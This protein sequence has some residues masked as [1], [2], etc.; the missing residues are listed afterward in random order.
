[1]KITDTHYIY[2]IWKRGLKAALSVSFAA[3]IASCTID[4]YESGDGKYSYYSADMTVFSTAKD[5]IDRGTLDDDRTL[6][7]AQPISS[8]PLKK[9]YKQFI[10]NDSIRMMLFYNKSAENETVTEAS[11]AISFTPVYVPNVALS[12]TLKT[13][14]KNDPVNL[15]SA[16]KSKNGKYYNINI[17]VK[18]GSADEKKPHIIGLVCDSVSYDSLSV[19]NGSV[20]KKPKLHLRLTHDQNNMPLYYSVELYISITRER[21]LAILNHYGIETPDDL[22]ISFTLNTFNGKKQIEL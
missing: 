10:Y 15:I 7:L 18:T 13:E 19:A 12:D 16:W 5:K 6:I 11:S 21:L 1:M 9:N 2:N 4:S 14:T 8:A 22:E 20:T 3:A 17:S